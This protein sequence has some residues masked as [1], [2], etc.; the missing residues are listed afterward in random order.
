MKM[1]LTMG[2]KE[3]AIAVPFFVGR[4]CRPP[5]NMWFSSNPPA[6]P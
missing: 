3:L 6:A 2:E 4:T 5:E 1:L